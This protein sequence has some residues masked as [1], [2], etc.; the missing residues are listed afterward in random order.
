MVANHNDLFRY[1]GDRRRPIRNDVQTLTLV[2]DLFKRLKKVPLLVSKTKWK[3]CPE[4]KK[5]SVSECQEKRKMNV[6]VSPR[7]PR[8]FGC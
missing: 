5:V 1:I 7:D 8:S 6:S 3:E 2:H 4:K